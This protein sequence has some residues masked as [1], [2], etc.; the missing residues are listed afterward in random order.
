MAL[1]FG[2]TKIGGMQYNGVTIGEA[3]YNGQ[4]VYRSEPPL[5]VVTITGTS[6][7]QSRDQFRQACIDFGTTYDTVEVLPFLLDTSQATTMYGV[8][9][10]C[11]SL[12]QVPDL[13]TANVT[14]MY[15]MFWKCSSLTQVP[16]LNT[17]NVTDMTSMFDGC[18]ALTTVPDMDTSQ[19]TNMSYMFWKCSSLTQVPDL[20]TSNVTNMVEMFNGCTSLTTVP[21]MDTGNVTNMY[22]MFWLCSALTLVPD[23][24]TANVTDMTSMFDRCSSLTQAPNLDTAKVVTTAY[25][26]W[27]CSALTQVPDLNTA[28][29]TNMV[30]MF[31]GCSA[32]TDGNVWLIGKNPSVNTASMIAGSGLTREPFRGAE[33]TI[34]GRTLTNNTLTTLATHTITAAEGGNLKLLRMTLA[35]GNATATKSIR[36]D[37]NGVQVATAAGQNPTATVEVVCNVGDVITYKAT[38]NSTTTA[39][40]VINSG[41][42]G[43]WNR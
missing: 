4:I 41:T 13:N 28:T 27:N 33:G 36:I 12:T 26:F 17:A 9:Y 39:N 11:T 3:M 8:F 23:L 10:G 31:F 7:T 5:P 43:A 19:V 24:N 32:L 35:W 37:R 38:V 40:R 6:G 15:G 25:M 34:T 18:S 30:E 42:W 2:P 21:D 20:N 1:Q 16:D 14:N 22:G 29:V